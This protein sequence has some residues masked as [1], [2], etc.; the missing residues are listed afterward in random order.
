[1]ETMIVQMV[2]KNIWSGE[3][4][5]KRYLLEASDL[6]RLFT[7]YFQDFQNRY[8]YCNGIHCEIEDIDK[9]VAYRKWLTFDNYAKAGGDC[10]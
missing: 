6:D 7:I 10:W 8:K 5:R 3:V 4:T 2:D 9:Q 1:M